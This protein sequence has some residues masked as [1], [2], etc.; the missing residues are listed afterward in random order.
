MR[1]FLTRRAAVTALAASAL[2]AGAG[3]IAATAANASTTVTATTSVANHPDTTI[4]GLPGTACGTSPNGPTWASDNYTSTITAVANATPANTYEVTIHD[5][6]TYTAF[7]D[8]TTCDPLL[9]TGSL[10]GDYSLSVTSTTA[11]SASALHASYNGAV[12]TT[13]MVQDLFGDN[14]SSVVG[15]DYTF[16]YQGGNYVQNT[17]GETGDVKAV[18]CTV[19]V[20]SIADHTSV[21]NKAISTLQVAATSNYPTSG[22]QYAAK[23]LPKGL[24]I[25]QA[26][27]KI[28]GTPTATGT[29]LVTVGAINATYTT[30]AAPCADTTT[31]NWTVSLTTPSP[32]SSPS[33]NGYPKGGV[34]TGGGKPVSSPWLPL[35][36]ALAGIGAFALVGG[37]T[38]ARRR[39]QTR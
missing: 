20:S 25:D 2:L 7:A 3:S 31:F 32:S 39:Q 8:P 26:T 11:P 5:V 15:G 14:A 23:N 36:A 22:M 29:N 21:L 38:V 12:S 34:A 30:E 9:S 35:G 27:G 37:V 10:V 33:G 19:T 4:G 1:L 6:G 13:Q 24:Q 16:S 17:A 18:A 28:T